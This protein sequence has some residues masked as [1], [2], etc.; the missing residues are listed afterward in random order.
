M[1]TVAI[2]GTA[3]YTGQETLDRVLNHPGLEIVA[4]GSDS[5]AG[6][7][8]TSLDPRL[9][10]NGALPA[11]TTNAEA[12]ASGADLFFWCLSNERAAELDPPASGVVVDLSGAH[13]IADTSLYPQ[14]YGFEHPKPERQGEWCYALTELLPP[15]GRLIAN[16]GCYATAAILALAP[17]RDA[18]DPDSVVVDAKSGVSGA[19]RTPSE[20]TLAG[21]VLENHK[22]YSIGRHRHVLELELMLGFAPAFVPHLLPIRR[23][24]LATCYVRGVSA[25]DARSL[26]SAAYAGSPVIQ[27]LPEGVVPEIERVVHTDGVELAVFA[28]PPSGRT[29]VIAAE[30]NL[31]KGAAGQAMQNANLALG[32]PETDGLRLYGVKV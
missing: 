14:W 21:S 27:V 15:T 1:K 13:R 22:P 9:F 18:V 19:G 32:L 25:D 2:L 12:A 23:G 6:Q 11:L 8:A 3:G 5:Q 29:V 20:T 4:L 17:L 24:L 30:D 7:P 16:P 28:D 26:L 31:G 10:R